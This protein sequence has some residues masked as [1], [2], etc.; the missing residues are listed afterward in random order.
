MTMAAICELIVG[1]VA[2]INHPDLIIFVWVSLSAGMLVFRVVLLTWA[3]RQAARGRSTPTAIVILSSLVWIA[4]L[5]FGCL[6]CDLSGDTGL[7]L[8][9]NVCITAVLGG[10]IARNA[11]TPRLAI[12]QVAIALAFVC[13]GAWL[14]P[15]H[16]LRV[17]LL[18]APIY[19]AGLLGICG[20]INRE[21]VALLMA[22]RDNA[23]LARRDP[24]TGLP[25]RILVAETL[26]AIISQAVGET[27]FAVIC[28]DLDGFKSVNDTLGHAAGDAVLVEAGLRLSRSCTEPLL[29]SRLGGDEFLIVLAEPHP[30]QAE[31]LA[32]T[33]GQAIKAPFLLPDAPSVRIDASFG[34][35]HF[36]EDGLDADAVLIAADKALYAVKRSGK[37]D[38]ATYDR[39]RHMGD[40]DLIALRSDLEAALES[41]DQLVLHYQPVVGLIDG[42][43][44]A[45]EALVRWRHPSK[46][47]IGPADFIPMAEASGLII[48]LGEEVLRRACADAAAWATPM[49]VAVNVSPVQLRNDKLAPTVAAV[50]AE[51]GLSAQYLEIEITETALLCDDGVTM[52]NMEALGHMGVR[53]VLDDFGTGYSSLANLCRFTF[54]RIKIDGSFVRDALQS[55]ESAAI[56]RAT[57]ALAHELGMPTTAECIETAEQ[58]EFVR[59]CGCTDVQGFLVGKPVPNGLIADG[60]RQSAPETLVAAA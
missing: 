57:V 47:M 43:T 24:L 20:K 27:R 54:D 34:V 55:R 6:V 7:Q 2:L 3:N 56:V 26:D 18:Q 22:R 48:R 39:L 12:T 5:G 33:I 59:A 50:L 14:A 51:T 19:A 1:A 42:V 38:V 30:G 46:G 28:M 9:S 35:A 25:N 58:L 10:L 37:G 40:R 15:Q 4:V 52:S 49:R 16:W 44:I 36:P 13:L 11:S 32:R 23:T 60:R 45:R 29:V 41:D 8:L 31:G 53:L 17:L 21:L